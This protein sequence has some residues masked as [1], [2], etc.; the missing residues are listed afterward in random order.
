RNGDVPPNTHGPFNFGKPDKNAGKGYAATLENAKNGF[1]VAVGVGVYL[2]TATAYIA[3]NA[4]V[5]AKGTL[6]VSGKTLNQIDPTSLWGVN[7]VT[8]FLDTTPNYT[9]DPAKYPGN[10]TVSPGQTVEVTRDH[11][12]PGDQGNWY[13]YIGDTPDSVNLATEDFGDDARW[14]D[15]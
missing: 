12:G 1:A 11:K 4:T 7:L 3:G 2:D 9:T 5:D 15:L 8:P 13:E 10:T 6:T 14:K